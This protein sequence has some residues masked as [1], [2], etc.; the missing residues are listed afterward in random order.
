MRIADPTRDSEISL[1]LRMQGNLVNPTWAA[2]LSPD[3]FSDVTFTMLLWNFNRLTITSPGDQLGPRQTRDTVEAL[4]AFLPNLRDLL[5]L[6]LPIDYPL[7]HIVSALPLCNNLTLTSSNIDLFS[8]SRNIDAVATGLRGFDHLRKL[9]LPSNALFPS[10]HHCLGTL[11]GLEEIKVLVTSR[12]PTH[13]TEPG[14]P[15]YPKLQTLKVVGSFRDLEQALRAF[16][17]PEANQMRRVGVECWSN[18]VDKGAMANAFNVL[19]HHCPSLT[20]LSIHVGLRGDY[21][22]CEK[23]EWADLSPLARLRLKTFK[24][25]HPKTKTIG[26]LVTVPSTFALPVPINAISLP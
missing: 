17:H 20:R 11:Q 3:R 24:F 14:P 26:R 8:L 9:C 22:A 1:T 12:F 2:R 18:E 16:T 25:Q 4:L 15:E 10:V 19:I 13:L 21:D 5:R 23:L 6:S 7:L